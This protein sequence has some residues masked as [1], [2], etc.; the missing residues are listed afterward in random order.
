MTI[1]SLYKVHNNPNATALDYG[2]GILDVIS[3]GKVIKIYKVGHLVTNSWKD[4][5]ERAL[6]SALSSVT[7][8]FILSSWHH[9]DYRQNE[10]IKLLWQRFQILTKEHFY[11]LGGK[12]ENRN[13]MVEALMK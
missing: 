7:G 2:M 6:F 12:E 8:K 10:Y 3:L 11:H 4:T 5:Q 9:N 1:R 13:S